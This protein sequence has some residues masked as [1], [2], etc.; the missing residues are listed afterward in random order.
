MSEI[1]EPGGSRD[2]LSKAD[3]FIKRRRA[4]LGSAVV[5]GPLHIETANAVTD[6]PQQIEL[7][8]PVEDI[9]LLTEVVAMAGLP[10]TL[11]QAESLPQRDIS[12]E[13]TRELDAWLD[14]A[15]PQAVLHV[16]D[17]ITDRLIQQVLDSARADLLPRL[18]R[19]LDDEAES[20]KQ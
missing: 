14:E 5:D 4:Q 13:V 12:A 1:E 6:V 17:G 11:S 3:E 10:G 2:V 8:E 15:L 18:K 20:G 9:P 7:A 19:A 16:M